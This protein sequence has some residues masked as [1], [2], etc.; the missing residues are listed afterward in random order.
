M[1]RSVERFV[2]LGFAHHRI[3][4]DLELLQLSVGHRHAYRRQHGLALA[5]PGPELAVDQPATL[6][7][8]RAQAILFRDVA[9]SRKQLL[10]AV[11]IHNTLAPVN[12]RWQSERKICR[13]EGLDRDSVRLRS[14]R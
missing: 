4:A 6:V 5:I 12:A 10:Q 7:Y 3:A 13:R 11:S 14:V 1:H 9:G 2:A 8:R